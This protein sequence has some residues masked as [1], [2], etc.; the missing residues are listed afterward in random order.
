MSDF[1]GFEHIVR[2]QESLAPFTS[3]R[4]GGVGEF[5]AEPTSQPELVGLVGRCH[6][7]QIPVRILGSGSNLLI[8][9][10]SVP[11]MVIYLSAAEFSEITVDGT[12]VTAGGGAALVQL[13]STAAREGLE[14]LEQLA[15]IPGTVGGALRANVG[16]HSGDIGQRTEVVSVLT[17]SGECIDRSGDDLRFSYKESSLN[18]LVILKARFN[19]VHGDAVSITRKMQTQWIVNKSLQPQ[20]GERYLEMFRDHSGLSAVS[21]I[22]QAGLKGAQ[23]GGVSIS[24]S[25]PNYM[26]IGETATCEQA[27]GLLEHIQKEVETQL[28]V[29]LQT[30]V[31]IW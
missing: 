5:F 17:R 30:Q 16:T 2:E 28:G 26:V 4:F 27:M 12:S 15:G 6:S 19:L 20:G 3:L 14:G 11:G 31:E 10:E 22:E 29:S 23:Q 25:H 18:E 21:L 8:A 9:S 13:L 7:N 24:E 1:N